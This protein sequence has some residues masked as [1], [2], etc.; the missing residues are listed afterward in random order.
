MF[1]DRELELSIINSYKDS[2]DLIKN[3]SRK[4]ILKQDLDSTAGTF[5]CDKILEKNIQSWKYL[6]ADSS[7]EV[8][9][10]IIMEEAENLRE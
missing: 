8:K 2:V 9:I 10:T 7:S 1:S 3:L 5:V 6:N 4:Y